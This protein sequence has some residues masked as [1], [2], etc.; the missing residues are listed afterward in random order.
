MRATGLIF[1]LFALGLKAAAAQGATGQ[2]D[3]LILVYQMP[4]GLDQIGFTYAKSVPHSQALSD[5][6]TLQNET[7][8]AAHGLQISDAVGPIHSR[9]GKMT[10]VS[11]ASAGVAPYDVHN[12]PVEPFVQAFRGY[13]Q[14]VLAFV[15][16]RG[17]QFQGLRDY[18][19]NYVQIAME[20]RNSAYTYRIRIIDPHFDQLKLPAVQPDTPTATESRASLIPAQA[21]G[22]RKALMLIA[23]ALAVGIG[24]YVITARFGRTPPC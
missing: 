12:F 10:S 20:Q 4:G 11:F 22:I 8:W 3:V 13:H 9:V 1:L 6:H 19:D 16:D 23:C 24:V 21:F 14:I 18:T 15:A 7:H 17:Y 2:P 5:L